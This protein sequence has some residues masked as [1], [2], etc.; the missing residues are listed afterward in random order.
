MSAFF[1]RKWLGNFLLCFMVIQ[2][3][4]VS[5]CSVKMDAAKKEME[6]LHSLTNLTDTRSASNLEVEPKKVAPST[7]QP[8]QRQEPAKKVVK[9]IYVSAWS[10]VGNKFEQLINLVDQTDL[11]AMVID[12]KNDSG[13]VTYASAV[14]LVNEI[15]ANSNV[16][17]R[18]LKGTLQRL[19]NKQI[20]T[21]ARVVVFKDPYLSKKKSDYAMKT[22]Q[23]SVWKD[24][25]GVAW[26]DPYKDEVWDYNLQIA[27]EAT[28]LGFDEIQFD[29]VRF[30]ENSKRVDAEVKFDNPMKWTKAQVIEAFLKKAK[31]RI[32]NQ[33]YLSADV[34]GLTTSSDNDMGIGQDWSMISKQVHYISPMLY[35][36]HYSNG[37]YGVKYPDLQPYAIIHKAISDANGKNNTLLQGSVPVAEIRPWYQDFT[38]TW[39]KPHKTYG[40]VDVKEQIKA[41]KEQGVEQFLLWNSNSIYSYR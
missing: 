1:V 39:V 13:Q 24:N 22:I 26:V 34:F 27:K 15:G 38:A 36:S 23:G 31:E 11:N 9:G 19:K 6:P 4:V 33:A 17:I 37:M 30:P 5:G 25:K 2:V 14:P 21:I 41:A 7:E 16:I 18:D 32:G 10:A 12:V 40:N 35:P 28:Q 8:A 20:Y 29:Y 3:A